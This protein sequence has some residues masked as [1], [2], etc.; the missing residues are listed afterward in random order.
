[1]SQNTNPTL[2][3]LP[4]KTIHHI[5]DNLD[6]FD[7][8]VSLHGVCTHLDAIVNHYLPY[9]VTIA[10]VSKYSNRTVFWILSNWNTDHSSKIESE[11][12]EPSTWLKCQSEYRDLHSRFIV[13]VKWLTLFPQALT[14]LNLHEH[15]I[16]L[17]GT[18]QLA[19]A[20]QRNTVSLILTS[21]FK[22]NVRHILSR[23]SQHSMLAG[24]KS[25]RWGLSICQMP[26]RITRWPSWSSH[27]YH[28]L[29]YTFTHRHSQ[30]LFSITIGSETK[31]QS[32]LLM[33]CAR[34]RY[35]W[36]TMNLAIHIFF[37][38]HWEHL[39]CNTLKS[40][41]KEHKI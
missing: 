24:I 2:I 13:N 20:L 32:I 3:S 23:Q 5:L 1:M 21:S 28:K 12:R 39:N 4:V 36:L 37:N 38:R 35:N 8:L 19:E 9:Q 18:Q 14:T 31:D 34:T 27:R 22:W 10:F 17:Q 11:R 41:L 6:L 25:G 16:G 26:Y 33:H 29:I 30:H 40:A 7:I 15:R